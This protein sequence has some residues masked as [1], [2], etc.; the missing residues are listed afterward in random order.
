[1]II[2]K[3]V[4]QV[5]PFLLKHV[6]KAVM[7]EIRATNIKNNELEKR[8]GEIEKAQH[9]IHKMLKN[10]KNIASEYKWGKD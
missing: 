9:E 8:I 1:M 2:N 3:L 7:P 10:K 5:L 6:W 4:K